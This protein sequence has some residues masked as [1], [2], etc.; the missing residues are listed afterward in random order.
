[1]PIVYRPNVPG[2][3]FASRKLSNSALDTKNATSGLEKVPST[4][5]QKRFATKLRKIRWRIYRDIDLKR[6]NIV[7]TLKNYKKQVQLFLKDFSKILK[8]KEPSIWKE[9]VAKT[10]VDVHA[11]RSKKIKA[12]HCENCSIKN[13]DGI[14][15]ISH[16]EFKVDIPIR[17]TGSEELA[18]LQKQKISLI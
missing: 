5:A 17:I 12:K 11:S 6:G 8:P 15:A 16:S 7:K 2:G 4:A 1:M 14:D 3:I 9:K 10:S 18:T 13:E